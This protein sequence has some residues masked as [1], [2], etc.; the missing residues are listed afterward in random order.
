[1]ASPEAPRP[2]ARPPGPLP[3]SPRP[4]G[5]PSAAPSGCCRPGGRGR[6]SGAASPGTAAGGAAPAPARTWVA[7][8]R[9]RF[10]FLPGTVSPRPA[11]RSE[12]GLASQETRQGALQRWLRPAAPPTPSEASNEDRLLPQME[13]FSA[14]VWERPAGPGQVEFSP[15]PFSGGILSISFFLTFQIKHVVW[16]HSSHLLLRSSIWWARPDV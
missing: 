8:P 3:T 2:C 15:F 7:A 16:K 5:S 6:W 13:P 1:M 11:P 12:L 10:A 14:L 9:G 4:T